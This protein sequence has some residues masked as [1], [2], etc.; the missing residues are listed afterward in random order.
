MVFWEFSRNNTC[1]SIPAKLSEGHLHA[2][3][4][5]NPCG[6]VLIIVEISW[7]PDLRVQ[8]SLSVSHKIDTIVY[9]SI[10]FNKKNC[11]QVISCNI[12]S[13][14]RVYSVQS[15]NS[16]VFGSCTSVP[17]FY[18]NLSGSHKI[19]NVSVSHKTVIFSVLVRGA[20]IWVLTMVF[21]G[22]YWYLVDYMLKNP[23]YG[24]H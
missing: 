20:N 12:F 23:A 16:Q 18:I 1:V 15:N 4:L 10:I 13:S 11:Y 19:V 17:I 5:S 3:L 14:H 6:K 8:H 24:R 7:S 2:W 21:D 22:P 9:F